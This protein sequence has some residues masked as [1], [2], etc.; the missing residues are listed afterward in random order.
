LKYPEN[1]VNW[2]GFRLK[3]GAPGAIDMPSASRHAARREGDVMIPPISSEI[4]RF[5]WASEQNDELGH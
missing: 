5:V 2:S 3:R 1:I 4:S